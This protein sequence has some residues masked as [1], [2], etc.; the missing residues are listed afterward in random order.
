MARIP[1]EFFTNRTDRDAR[2]NDFRHMG[3]AVISEDV[4]CGVMDCG[5]RVW[6]ARKPVPRTH[7]YPF[8]R[9]CVT[10]S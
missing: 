8:G 5:R 3:F 2:F 7:K 4:L 9:Y 6:V 1:T 10:F